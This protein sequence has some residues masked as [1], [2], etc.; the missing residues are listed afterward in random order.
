MT[1][2]TKNKLVFTINNRREREPSI[3][4]VIEMTTTA[5]TDRNIQEEEEEEGDL[6]GVIIVTTRWRKIIVII[7]AFS[8]IPCIPPPKTRQASVLLV[9]A[10]SVSTY[11]FRR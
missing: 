8:G 1:N 4:P 3:L 11:P 9:D 7:D 2:I 10:D 5:S 6:K